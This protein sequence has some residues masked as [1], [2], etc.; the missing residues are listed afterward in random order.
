[1]RLIRRFCDNLNVAG[2]KNPAQMKRKKKEKKSLSI[3][4]KL[5]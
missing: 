1:M 4:I 3:K 2:S 5:H